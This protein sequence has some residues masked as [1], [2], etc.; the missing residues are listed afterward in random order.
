MK[1]ETVFLWES[2]LDIWN[3]IILKISVKKINFVKYWTI[4]D[5]PFYKKLSLL[6]ILFKVIWNQNICIV[7]QKYH[8]TVSLFSI[9]VWVDLYLIH[10]YQFILIRLWVMKL[11]IVLLLKAKLLVFFCFFV[12]FVVTFFQSIIWTTSS[13]YILASSVNS[14]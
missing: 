13:S 12:V 14:F 9:L 2:C 6:Q 5:P 7:L 8:V 1:V 10:E 3:Q 4:I 11:F